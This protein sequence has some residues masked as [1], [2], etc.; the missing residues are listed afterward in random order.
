[1]RKQCF[2]RLL[3]S[4]KS[5][6]SAAAGGSGGAAPRTA[7]AG[8]A[9]A[10]RRRSRTCRPFRT[11]GSVQSDCGD[12]AAANRKPNAICNTVTTAF[13]LLICYYTNAS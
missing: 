13:P 7:P 8:P 12:A 4:G 10:A 3:Q 11:C 6:R 9:A 1:M 5:G 2:G